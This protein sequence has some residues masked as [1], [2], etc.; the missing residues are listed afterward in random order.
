MSIL[1]EFK[2]KEF[3]LH[4]SLA[5]EMALEAESHNQQFEKYGNKMQV[6]SAG[7]KNNVLTYI[8][9]NKWNSGYCNECEI[10]KNSC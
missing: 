2:D 7:S 10:A 6:E 1:C 9:K 3:F 5:F 8:G 4:F